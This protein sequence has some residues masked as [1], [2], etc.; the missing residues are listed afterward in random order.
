VDFTRR[1]NNGLQWQA[2][3]V[4]SKVLSDS[5]GDGQTRFEPF[6]DIA[7]A[8]IERARTPFDLT[9]SFKVNAAYELPVGKGR[10]MSISNPVLDRVVGGWAVSGF[11]TW[12]SGAPFSVNSG[13]GTLN[14]TGRSGGNTANSSLNKGQ[15]DDLLRFRQTGNGPYFVGAS[16]IGADGRAVA[17]DG[18]APFTGQVF[19]N[20]GAGEVGGLQR[21]MFS[22]PAFWNTDLRILKTFTIHETHRLELSGDLFNFTNTPSF[23]INDQDI[24]SVNFGRITSTASDRRVVQFGLYYRF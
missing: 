16:A 1:F 19:S 7:N 9:H 12:T 4:Y 6:L 14:R 18:T 23:F 2:N 17:S 13:R 24:N 3:Y 11:M 10:K 21:R 22:G 20:P 5:A 15:L 8:G